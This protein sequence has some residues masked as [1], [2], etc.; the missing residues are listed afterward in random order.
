[1]RS[2]ISSAIF[3]HLNG[4]LRSLWASTCAKM[5]STPATTR[6]R[7]QTAGGRMN[8]RDYGERFTDCSPRQRGGRFGVDDGE[9]VSRDRNCPRDASSRHRSGDHERT[10]TWGTRVGLQAR[11]EYLARMREQY[12]TANRPGKSRLVDEVRE[13]TGYHRKAAVRLLRRGAAAA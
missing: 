11:R 2:R 10:R 4:V 5:A 9:D 7:A 1:M 8:V 13:V 6:P 3:T 12:E